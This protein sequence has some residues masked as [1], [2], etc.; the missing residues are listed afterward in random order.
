MYLLFWMEESNFLWC[1]KCIV[2]YC[3]CSYREGVGAFPWVLIKGGRARAS[4][5]FQG[6]VEGYFPIFQDEFPIFQD[7]F[8]K[9][10]PAPA[11]RAS[12]NTQTS[13]LR[14][15]Y[16]FIIGYP[17]PQPLNYVKLGLG[18]F[19]FWCCPPSSKT[20]APAFKKLTQLK[21]GS[22]KELF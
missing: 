18:C 11:L 6:P 14:H 17:F 20:V 4:L 7:V 15:F 13:Q 16:P 5:I 1:L 9:S 19:V 8:I 21:V 3:A 12:Y 2:F 22:Q 10:F